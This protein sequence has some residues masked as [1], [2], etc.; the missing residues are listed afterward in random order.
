MTKINFENARAIRHI[1][2]L[3][4]TGGEGTPVCPATYAGKTKGSSELALS[5]NQPVMKYDGEKWVTSKDDDGAF[6][7]RDSV[8]IS[9]NAA[10]AHRIS[11][12]IIEN[13]EHLGDKDFLPGIFLNTP[14]DDKLKSIAEIA[15]AK[16][17]DHHYT[18]ETLAQQ[19]KTDIESGMVSSWTA[20]HRHVDSYIRHAEIDGKQIW[21]DLQSEAAK[22]I[23][24]AYGDGGGR[25]LVK[26]F[27]NSAILGFWLSSNAPRRHKWARALSS[28]IIGYD[29]HAIKRGSTKNDALG[30]IN[31]KIT[32][33][34]KNGAIVESKIGKPSEVGL[35]Q[36]PSGPSEKAFSCS[37]ILHIAT[38][39]IAHL[40][41]IKDS[42]TN[43]EED[44]KHVVEMLTW[45]SIYG[46]LASELLEY[47][48]I[49]SG[50][51]LVQDASRSYWEVVYGDGST[52]KFEISLEE[53]AQQFKNAYNAMPEDWKF[54]NRI[55][56]DYSDAILIA[57][58][59][60]L[61]IESV[62]K[63]VD[64]G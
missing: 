55:N 48:F 7:L 38:I 44:K 20:A 23:N 40:K 27:P 6:I 36:V 22:I 15:I 31:S 12:A 18:V 13:S 16:H 41:N 47:G 5:E 60:T 9:S 2:A 21:E 58:A 54:A 39:S 30:G 50:T 42:N 63:E 19:L 52:K 3:I 62:S 64:E 35:G 4:P 34:R 10:Q 46:I 51:D 14:S 24:G 57:R 32:L 8:I 17:K 25:N 61:L 45:L 1:G 53:A 28:E 43:N 33:T 56:A 49:R 29:A 11:T 37:N 59:R 26:Y